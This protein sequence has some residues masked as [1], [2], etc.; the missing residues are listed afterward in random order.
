[1]AAAL[2]VTR[3]AWRNVRRN[4][5]HSLAAMLSIVVGFLAM[6]L[7]DGY[8]D[9]LRRSQGD[10]FQNRY[11]FGDLI[12]DREE[13]EGKLGREDP[14][15]YSLSVSDQ[16]FLDEWIAAHREEIAQRVRFV[17]ISGL[18]SAGQGGAIFVGYGYDVE[19]GAKARRTW[20]WDAAAG[21]PLQESPPS[22]VML[23]RGLGSLLDCVPRPGN[24]PFL[25]RDGNPT[26]ADR[27]LDCRRRRIQ[28]T[29]T[30]ETGQLNAVEPEVAG[31]LDAGIKEL[32]GRLLV[33][34]LPLAQKLLDS[35]ILTWV[36]LT[37]VHPERAA[38]LGVDLRSAASM[39]GIQLAARPWQE[40][41]V[42][43]LY[44]RGIGL[45]AVY[46]TLVVVVVVTIAGMSVLTT[47]MK[48]VTERIREIG[49]LRSIGFLRR[50]IL[51]LFGVEA[52]LLALVS[53][54]AGLAVTVALTW[55]LN[56]SGITYKAGVLTESIPL[57]IAWLPRAWI[58]AA[59][60][61]SGVAAAAA[62]FAARRAVR[63]KIP[64]A[65]GHA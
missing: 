54:A 65:L 7:F 16:A 40:H 27:P 50:H 14:F 42:G 43:E 15:K 30:T 44:K 28:V 41:P 48:T 45:L 3:M 6:G 36:G 4:W 55:L 21:K 62:L 17:N 64:D 19:E 49:T 9:D 5:R 51:A 60:F 33:L 13:S 2:P 8:L 38:A 18:V 25:G 12:V 32:D 57:T 39:K 63:M 61:L 58:V 37:L 20:L 22:S 26:R 56:H 47:M 10:A 35:K 29:A 46:R 31:L 59:L 11:M 23:G 34:P 52:A 53:S 1:M 24:P